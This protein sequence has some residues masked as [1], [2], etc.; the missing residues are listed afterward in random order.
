MP[1]GKQLIGNGFI[2]A[3][4]NDPKHTA[5]SVTNY[6]K[7]KVEKGEIKVL[8]WPSQSPDLNPIENLW[9]IVKMQRKKFKATSKDDLFSKIQRIWR[10]LPINTLTKLVES[11]PTRI[12]AVIAAKGGHTKY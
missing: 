3:H 4:D 9:N 2:F 8:S 10:E 5:I 12:Q 1:S 7:R 6:L 11:I